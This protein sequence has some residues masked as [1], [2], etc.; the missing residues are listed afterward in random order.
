MNS[1]YLKLAISNIKKNKSTFFPFGLSCGTMIALFYMLLSINNQASDAVFYGGSD[2]GIILGLGVW[3][4]GIFSAMVI[5]YTNGFLLKRRNKELGLYNILGMEKKHIGN[6]LFWEIILTCGIS[7]LAGLLGGMLF[8]KLMFLVLLNLINLSTT[9]NFGISV[10]AVIMTMLVFLSIF[11]VN[12]VYNNLK[13]RRLKPIE[14]LQGS[15]VGERE[16]KAK[17]ILALLGAVC[18]SIG[19]YIA[20]TTQNPLQAMSVFFVAVLFVMAGTY[21]L[22]IS[23]SI[24]LLKMLKKNKKYYYHKTHFI[25]VSGMMYRMKQNAVGL[26]NICILSTAV[27]VVLSSTVSL[28][29]GMDNVMRTRYPSDVITSYAYMPEEDAKYNMSYN[30]DTELVEKTIRNHAD[31]YNVEMQDVNKYYSFSLVG[32]VDGESFR[33]ITDDISQGMKDM[34]IFRA[35]TLDDYKAAAAEGENIKE[36]PGDSLYLLS[37]DSRYSSMDN[38]TV[39]ENVFKIDSASQTMELDNKFAEQTF[40]YDYIFIIVPDLENLIMVKD[41]V[42]NMYREREAQDYGATSVTY[43]YKFNLSGDL[44]DKKEFN[45]TLR[46][47]L[48]DADIP[49][50]ST[51]ENIFTTRQQF[52]E[53]YGSLFF[54]G[55][56]IGTLFLMATVL[57]IY[58]KQVSEGYEDRNRFLIM[59]NVGMSKKEVRTVIKNQ[60]LTIFYL[61]ILLAVVHVAFAF[62]ITRKILAILNLTNVKL[63]VECTLGTIF[64]FVIIYGIVYKLTAK[65]YYKIVNPAN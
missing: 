62:D 65:S 29:M 38:F 45:I 1:I 15:N 53:L 3:V 18:L 54:I 47:A 41:E 6:I 22:F 37:S 58:Y 12:I 36:L 44:D 16:P 14:L 30:Y 5:F 33:P 39:G 59:R 32:I 24:A 34:V 21:L 2:I 10:N 11:I 23:G 42:N 27:L 4:C 40:A 56:F 35:M 48:N 43:N 57:I 64:I 17:W 31:K 9:I 61:P 25:T 26:A 60:I 49:H 13:I 63:F 52:M 28:Y 20:V 50:V 8:S 55:I 19:Y 51:V 46:D 7:M